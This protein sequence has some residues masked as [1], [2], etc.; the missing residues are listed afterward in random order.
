[1]LESN[2]FIAYSL[3]RDVQ[4]AC[5][6]LNVLHMCWVSHKHKAGIQTG[7]INEYIKK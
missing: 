4:I 5:I 1:M 2:A 7:T 3:A 6:I